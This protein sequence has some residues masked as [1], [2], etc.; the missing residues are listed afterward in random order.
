MA[1]R[2]RL[3]QAVVAACSLSA[4]AVGQV[5]KMWDLQEV[6]NEGLGIRPLVDGAPVAENRVTVEGIALNTT[7]EILDPNEQYTIFLQDETGGLQVWAGSW[8][9]G[10]LW[11][12]PEYI[13][14]EAGDR[15]RVE[16]FL[17]NHNGKVFINDRHSSAL[18]IRFIVT[19]VEKGAGMPEPKRIPSVSACNYFDASRAGGG[20]KYQTQWCRLNNVEITSGTWGNGQQLTI[21]DGTGELTMLLSA[22]GDFDRYSAP[23]G[24]FDVIGIFDQEDTELPYHENYRIWVKSYRYIIPMVEIQK[25]VRVQWMS[26]NGVTYQAYRSDDAVNWTPLGDPVVGDGTAVSILDDT[27]GAWTKYYK[28][29]VQ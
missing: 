18:E 29:E 7:G 9:Y 17:A 10:D 14:V 15:V 13:N 20:E 23:T 25:V 26:A 12:P 22:Q 11:R 1:F 4:A 28:I 16:G 3:A 19:I 6:D 24:K 21:S 27:D 5:Y 8:W 2:V